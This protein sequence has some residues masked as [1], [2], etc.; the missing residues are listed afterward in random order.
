VADG[1]D[2]VLGRRVLEHDRAGADV[3]GLGHEAW[4]GVARVEDDSRLLADDLGGATRDFDAVQ[5]GE[6]D[7]EHD[8]GRRSLREELQRLEAGSGFANDLETF[9]T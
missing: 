5:V 1:A 3:E 4:V 6:P 7:V 2:Q 8:H 9:R